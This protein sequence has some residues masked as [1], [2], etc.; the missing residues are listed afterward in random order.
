[1]RNLPRRG[2]GEQS[3]DLIEAEQFIGLTD[4][5]T[6]NTKVVA[7]LDGCRSRFD[8]PLTAEELMC[9]RKSRKSLKS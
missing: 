6:R 8:S 2:L 3:A 4:A 9:R 1:M 7:R 5:V